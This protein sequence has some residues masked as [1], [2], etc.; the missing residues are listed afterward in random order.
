MGRG[1]RKC[2]KT[3]GEVCEGVA[4]RPIRNRHV[5]IKIKC[6]GCHV[7]FSLFHSQPQK[8][9]KP[10]EISFQ[11]NKDG[12]SKYGTFNAKIRSRLLICTTWALLF[13]LVFVSFFFYFNWWRRWIIKLKPSPATP[14]L[15]NMRFFWFISLG[16]LN[17]IL[18][19]LFFL[20]VMQGRTDVANT[21]LI[22]EFSI[23]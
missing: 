16:A 19:Q 23:K 15:E 18:V 20:T 8:P 7:I 1:A 11:I 10:N 2:S 9:K 6:P 5:D 12:W 22:M 3:R 21:V 13:P 14:N 4:P 17:V